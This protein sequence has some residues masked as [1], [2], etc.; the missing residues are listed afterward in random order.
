MQKHERS[1]ALVKTAPA[2]PRVKT[3]PPLFTATWSRSINSTYKAS[4]ATTLWNNVDL[5]V[6]CC[7]DPDDI[8]DEASVIGLGESLQV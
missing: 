5:E 1:G 2:A 7:R 6:Y 8:D 3:A 4:M